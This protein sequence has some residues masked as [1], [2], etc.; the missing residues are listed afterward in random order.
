MIPRWSYI[1]CYFLSNEMKG[2][3]Q[4]VIT[5]VLNKITVLHNDDSEMLAE[6]NTPVEE[7]LEAL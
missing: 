5:K 6:K 3:Q 4:K 7:A 1:Q 2:L